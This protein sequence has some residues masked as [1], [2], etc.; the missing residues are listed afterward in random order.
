MNRNGFLLAEETLKMIIAVVALV[1]LVGLLVKVYYNNQDS[2][3]L[4][5]AKSSLE[6]LEKAIGDNLIE[7]QIFN[8]DGWSF[9]TWPNDG[10]IPDVCS[11]MKWEKCICLCEAPIIKFSTNYLDNCNDG[12]T[13]ICFENEKDLGIPSLHIEIDGITVLKINYEDNE[14]SK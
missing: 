4:E 12:K 13:G 1:V 2:K 11:N 3:E 8:P 10:E 9:S 6:K 14:I 7:V 5:L